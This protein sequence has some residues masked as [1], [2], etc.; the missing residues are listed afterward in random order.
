MWLRV[1]AKVRRR[2]ISQ[3]TGRKILGKIWSCL[4]SS[5]VLGV[6]SSSCSYCWLQLAPWSLQ[7]DSVLAPGPQASSG[8]W[9]VPFRSAHQAC[10]SRSYP[11][12]WEGTA[13]AK[14]TRRSLK[15]KDAEGAGKPKQGIQEAHFGTSASW[16]PWCQ[17]IL[18]LRAKHASSCHHLLPA[19]EPG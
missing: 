1:V 14:V 19:H 8:I 9:N 12:P 17:V 3:D 11:T 5:P 15:E 6:Q 7:H 16:R 2:R 18:T 13:A 4:K 10:Q